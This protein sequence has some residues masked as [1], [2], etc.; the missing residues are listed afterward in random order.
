MFAN[1]NIWLSSL[2]GGFVSCVVG[3]KA[4]TVPSKEANW[5]RVGTSGR[6][7]QKGFANCNVTFLQVSF[8]KLRS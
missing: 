4:E 1:C 6:D 2:F 7:I 3:F 5:A 8:F